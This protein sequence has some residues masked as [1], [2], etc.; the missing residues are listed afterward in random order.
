MKFEMLTNNVKIN[1]RKKNFAIITLISQ[2][3]R[4]GYSLDLNQRCVEGNS[5]SPLCPYYAMT[6]G[7]YYDFEQIYLCDKGCYSG[8]MK[9]IMYFIGRKCNRVRRAFLPAVYKSR[10]LANSG[11]TPV[12][13]NVNTLMLL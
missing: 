7:R 12:C 3:S 4:P 2:G 8:P 10:V 11:Q 9:S 6:S 5:L 1:V 13:K